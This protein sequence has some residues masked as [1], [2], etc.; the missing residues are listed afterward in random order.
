MTDD[1]EEVDLVSYVTDAL[2]GYFTA[3]NANNP[4]NYFEPDLHDGLCI[5][6][7]SYRLED[8]AKIA[9]SSVEDWKLFSGI[10]K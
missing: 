8:M 7:G 5:I 9:I 4:S 3:E 10:L 2:A 6:D 1:K